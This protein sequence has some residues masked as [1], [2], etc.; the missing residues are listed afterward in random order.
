[1]IYKLRNTCLA[2]VLLISATATLALP[3]DRQ[4]PIT[5]RSD[6]K[7]IETAT[8]LVTLS[9]NVF[10]TQ[11]N[12]EIFA[13]HTTLETNQTTKQL[14]QLIADGTPARFIDLPNLTSSKV[15]VSGSKIEFYPNKDLIITTGNAEISQNGNI[16]HGERIEYNTVTGLM[17]IH[18]QRSVTGNPEDDQA[19][20]II[21]PG[22]LD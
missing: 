15:E 22:A 21:I 6:E 19:E 4:L 16:V 8:G 7:T 18:S 9:G 20:L 1:M 17:N 10:I 3:E 11:G 5:G 13:D 2:F 12:L 14:E